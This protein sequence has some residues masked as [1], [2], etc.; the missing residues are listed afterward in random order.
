VFV[1]GYAMGSSLWRLLTERLAACGFSCLAPTWPLGAHTD[2]MSPDVEL[3]ME[4]IAAMVGEFLDALSLNDVVL[5][6]NDTGGAVSQIVA[7]STP[8]RLGAPVLTS[9]DAFEHPPADPQAVHRRGR[10]RTGV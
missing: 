10:V 5:V 3:T 8:E 6:G 9:C 4:A 2:P 1:H 7:T